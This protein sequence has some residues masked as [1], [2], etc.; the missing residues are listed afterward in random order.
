[1]FSNRQ[2]Q[3]EEIMKFNQPPSL[4]LKRA[5]SVFF[6]LNLFSWAQTPVQLM[7][8]FDSQ[9][10]YLMYVD[11]QYDASNKPVSRSIYMADGTFK[12]TTIFQDDELG[13]RVSEQSYNFDQQLVF[14]TTLNSS[15]GQTSFSVEDQ[16]KN[17]MLGGPVSYSTGNSST[18][19]LQQNNALV[20][21]ISYTNDATGKLSRIDITDK[22]GELAAYA[23]VYYDKSAR[24]PKKAPVVVPSGIILSKGNNFIELQLSLHQP[25]DVTC[26]L[27]SITGQKVK[28]ILKKGYGKGTHKEPIWLSPRHLSLSTGIY[29]VHLS[30]EGKSITHGKILL[31]SEGGA[32]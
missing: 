9:G 8:L 14:S 16:F 30:I 32:Q 12:R 10:N 3:V 7:Q 21:T 23:T 2:R 15:G 18:Y 24:I 26:D 29:F 4:G 1:M 31:T 19:A 22:S 5:I 11:F 27:I 13:N 17:D 20:S 6:L 28:T 25:S